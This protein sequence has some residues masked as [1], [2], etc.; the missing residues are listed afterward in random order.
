MNE[1]RGASHQP[2]SAQPPKKDMFL[3]EY[4][5]VDEGIHGL[6]SNWDKCILKLQRLRERRETRGTNKWG[7]INLQ[8]ARGPKP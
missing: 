8:T 3:P 7:N 1:G 5:P 4:S 6:L 2:L